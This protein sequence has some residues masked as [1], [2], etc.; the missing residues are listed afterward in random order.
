MSR[1]AESRSAAQFGPEDGAGE[2]RG[3][4]PRGRRLHSR[5]G[6]PRS[7]RW[8]RRLLEWVAVIAVAALVAVLIRTFAIEAYYVPS[9]SMEPTLQVGDRILVDKAFVSKGS[10]GDGTIVVFAHP[11]GDRP[12]VC[13]DPEAKDLVKRI[14]AGPG[15]TI[16]SVG[17]TVYVDGRPQAETYLPKG[18]VLGRPIPLQTVPKGRYFVMGDNRAESCDSRYWG[19]ITARSI[20]GPVFAIVWRHDHPW[21]HWF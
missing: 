7:T 8:G 19:T 11:P 2:A 10:L 12:G 15:Q 20:V 9:G 21:L 1:T 3:A 17:N 16:R 5:R 18:T 13:D 4:A 6:G 14:V